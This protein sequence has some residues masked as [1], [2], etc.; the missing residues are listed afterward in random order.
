MLN[1][2]QMAVICKCFVIYFHFSGPDYM[3]QV[4]L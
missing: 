2:F 3:I 1:I 4:D